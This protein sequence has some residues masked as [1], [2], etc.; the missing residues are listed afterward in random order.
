MPYNTNRELPDWVKRNFP[1]GVQSA[2]R[3]AFN[4]ALKQ[5]KGDEG[6][7]MAVAISVL[8]KMGW[9]K[10]DDKWI[11]A[12]SAYV[13][14][15]LYT[16]NFPH[17]QFSE[18]TITISVNDLQK[19]AENTAKFIEEGGKV[20][21][22]ISHP[23][24]EEEKLATTQ[25]YLQDVWVDEEEKKLYG[26]LS[27]NDTSEAKEWIQEG[28]L[29]S[30]SPGIY[31]DVITSA[32]KFDALIDH[33]ALT[34]SPHLLAQDEFI[35]INAERFSAYQI[36]FEN[37][38]VTG[39]SGGGVFTEIKKLLLEILATVKGE[40]FAS[41]EEAKKAQ[42]ARSKKYGIG[43][44]DG[45]NVT[46]PSEW[47]TVA[48]DDFLDPVN[49]RYPCPNAE[50]TRAAVRYW[51]KPAN[52]AQYTPQ[53][54][55][56]INRRLEEK[57]K[58]YKIGKYTES[59]IHTEEGNKMDL[60]E[61]KKENEGLKKQIEELQT[62]VADY[63]KAEKERLEAE[64]KKAISDFEARVD[65]LI[66]EK[67]VQPATKEKLVA[68][69]TTLYENKIE[70]ADRLLL[71]RFESAPTMKNELRQAV[72]SVN[73]ET[74]DYSTDE[75][76]EKVVALFEKR[77]RELKEKDPNGEGRSYL[78]Y[79]D[80]ARKQIIEEYNINESILESEV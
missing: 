19:I 14:D 53:E 6:K 65:K 69:F 41:R 72:V 33:I 1:D 12:E 45:G 2:F 40:N 9:V 46:K 66:E 37:N 21:L 51:G 10:R 16:G 36:F 5:Y 78:A 59:E 3:K 8:K 60:E 20:P 18:Q 35:P 62:K 56:I 68:D 49:Y 75:G 50:Q 71:E 55:A 54:R 25:G 27:L 29:K 11:K 17:P 39:E 44:K 15:L 48:D 38:A 13:K 79:Y 24:T 43:I 67:K 80:R 30:V 63:E 4:A 26:L 47:S 34:A 76:R 74:I 31:H 52:Q 7:A 73:N 32:G 64:K 61:L 58:Q 42:K 77:A 23:A 28:K 70:D 22:T 57:L